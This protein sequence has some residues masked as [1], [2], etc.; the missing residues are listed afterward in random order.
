VLLVAVEQPAQRILFP[1]D[2]AQSGE[3]VLHAELAQAAA[4]H[5]GHLIRSALRQR[6]AVANAEG[7]LRRVLSFEARPGPRGRGHS[8]RIHGGNARDPRGLHPPSP[9]NSV[10]VVL[11]T[12]RGGYANVLILIPRT[13][14]GQQCGASFPRRDAVTQ[15]VSCQRSSLCPGVFARKSGTRCPCPVA[16]VSQ[17]RKGAKKTC[18]PRF[19]CVTASLR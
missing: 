5:R 1:R 10:H 3:S 11:P 9:R 7:N 4:A 13:R 17:S 18:S 14:R 8:G 12:L 2:G 16:N 6:S 19:L 15:D